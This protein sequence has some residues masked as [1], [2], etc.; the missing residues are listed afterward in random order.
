[1][2]YLNVFDY[3]VIGVYFSILVVLGLYLQKKASASI[4]DY[5]LGGRNIPWW[6]LGISGMA[7]FLDVAGT[8]L[9]VSFLFLLG[10]RGLYIEFRGGV[11]LIL[12][13]TMLWTGKW[14]RRSQCI[15]GAEW[16]LYRFGRGF[17]GQFAQLVSALASITGTVGMIAYMVKGV[18]LFLSM[19]IPLTPF[20][21]AIILVGIA[22]IYTM[23]SGFYGVV[24]TDIFQSVIILVAVAAI[25]V[26]AVVKIGTI[27]DFPNLVTSVTGN[28]DWMSSKL[29]WKT[30]M[31]SGYEAY[32]HLMLFSFFYLL[33]NIFG[34]MGMGNEPKYFGA[35][36]D[37]ECGKLTILWIFL[38]TFRWPMMI[39]FAV[40]G[41][42]LVRDMFPDQAVLLQA[43]D[44]IKVNFES[45]D[46]SGWPSLL[47]NITNN[48]DEYMN[49]AESL[50]SVLGADW[51][52]KL[53]LLSFEGTVNPEKILPSV[54]L[55]NIPVGFRGMIL[56]ALVA[57]SMSTFDSNVN[58][59][60]GFFTRDI[61]QKFKPKATNKE[62]IYVSWAFSI[63]VVVLGFIFAY[64]IPSVNA[65]WGWITMGLGGGLLVPSVL[66]LYWWRFNGGGFAIGTVV[67]LV[68][69]VLH[70]QIWAL[71]VAVLPVG[72]LNDWKMFI[73][74]F[75]IG[76][77]ASVVGTY[78]TKP[79]DDNI[80]NNF[81]KTTKP[82]G[83][84]GKYK[85]I[86]SS[87]TRAVMDKEHKNDILALPFTV[88]WQVTLF[89]L[90]MLFIIRNYTALVITLIICLLSLL[91]VYYFWYRKLPE[92]NFYPDE[93][94]K[95][96]F[97]NNRRVS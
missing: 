89:M 46:K 43:A 50:S 97:A 44:I 23:V 60:T 82:F 85:N 39:A 78:L 79:T 42:F 63:A 53:H 59:A 52:S 67:G 22:T 14:H 12:A 84:W 77:I 7:N 48:P 88:L 38:M 26:M 83:F 65:I 27:D 17:G 31:P 95:E 74:M 61:Y 2:Q 20:W 35:R 9:I 13:V 30:E 91:G 6:A 51:A 94:N 90:P 92:D 1:M 72:E 96:H 64:K 62:L 11:A 58:M 93:D 29:Q 71:L 73:L 49:I 70:K 56:I 57:A 68:A 45:V 80:V 28:S 19:F 81:Y 86:L 66:R 10:P 16:M 21:C 33:R 8:M 87:E 69:A 76:L 40:L 55:H 15:T 5:F 47:A 37:A 25:S 3:S 18:G 41:V 24:F 54:I 32:K 36:N 4:E 34:G 75:V